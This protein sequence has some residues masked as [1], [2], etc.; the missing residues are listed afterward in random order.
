LCHHKCFIIS[1]LYKQ[2][3][4]ISNQLTP[5]Q[6]SSIVY[7]EEQSLFYFETNANSYIHWCWTS[8]YT[9]YV[10]ALSL[11]INFYFPQNIPCTSI[12]VSHVQQHPWYRWIKIITIISKMISL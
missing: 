10:L 6:H 11:S 12:T 1:Y 5:H 9:W 3:I 8:K 7:T 4:M 2:K